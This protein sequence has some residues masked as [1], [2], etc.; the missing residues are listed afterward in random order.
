MQSIRLLNIYNA[1]LLI[2]MAALFLISCDD[3]IC[4]NLYTS[5][6]NISFFDSQSRNSKTLIVDSIGALGTDSI[7]YREDTASLYIL[8]VNTISDST[9][10]I[11]FSNEN[12]DTITVSYTRTISLLS[13]DCGYSQAFE[14][15]NVPYTSFPEVIVKSSV[16]SITND[17]DIEIYF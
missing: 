14:Q 7:F 10:F 12:I 16:L 17:D 2:M 11:F 15:L 4:S 9:V 3:T 5:N 13:K 8:P 6:I 1:I